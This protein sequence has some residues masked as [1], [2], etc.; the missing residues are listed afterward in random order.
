MMQRAILCA[1]AGLLLVASTPAAAEELALTAQV[2]VLFRQALEFADRGEWEDAADRFGRAYALRQAP[3]IGYNLASALAEL[4][5]LVEAVEL[6]RRLER[7]TDTND[8]IRG[9]CA[10]LVERLSPRLGS[11]TV[12][13]N[14]PPDDV[15]V[16]I[17]GIELTPALLGVTMQVNPGEHQIRAR[18]YDEELQVEQ[19]RLAD[20]A[21]RSVVLDIPPLPAEPNRPEPAVAGE[22]QERRPWHRSWWFWTVVGVVTAGAVATA[23]AVPLSAEDPEPVDGSW[24]TITVP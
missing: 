4:D 9:R 6:L 8:D 21:S 10:A 2:R 13:L 15:V 24:G 5:Q 18:R 11:L 1:T 19:V 20:G 12:S 17:D 23:I 7:D 3:V 16:E 14:G 22:T